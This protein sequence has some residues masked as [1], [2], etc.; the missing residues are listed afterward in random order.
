MFNTS[1][2]GPRE[3]SVLDPAAIPIIY[4][5]KTQWTKSTFYAS[6]GSHDDVVVIN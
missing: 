1:E 2:L 5:P 4:G 3:L 6:N